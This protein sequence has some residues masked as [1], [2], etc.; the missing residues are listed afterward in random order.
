[1]NDRQRPA[2]LNASPSHGFGPGWT[3]RVPPQIDGTRGVIVVRQYAHQPSSVADGWQGLWFH[4]RIGTAFETF[5]NISK[6]AVITWVKNTGAGHI[7]V[8]DESTRDFA[9]L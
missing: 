8:E 6:P 4:P 5:Q 2:R 9:I 1:V 3:A 7:L